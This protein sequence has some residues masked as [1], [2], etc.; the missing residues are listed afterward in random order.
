[1]VLDSLYKELRVKDNFQRSLV[2]A[3]VYNVL[4]ANKQYGLMSDP[5]K[6]IQHK[7]EE[8]LINGVCDKFQFEVLSCVAYWGNDCAD[9][10]SEEL[11]L[12]NGV[13][14]TIFSWLQNNEVIPGVG[15]C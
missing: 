15:K 8:A 7:V 4:K 13:F 2:S 10:L 1:M 5:T 12:E 14:D 11:G 6:E 3:M 9:L